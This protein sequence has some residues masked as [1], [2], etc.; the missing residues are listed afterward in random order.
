MGQ[1]VFLVKSD[2]DPPFEP[3]V[4]FILKVNGLTL[5]MTWFIS[6]AWMF[7]INKS[8]FK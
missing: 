3:F 2:R 6:Y 4:F 5:T 8:L 1:E 7:E